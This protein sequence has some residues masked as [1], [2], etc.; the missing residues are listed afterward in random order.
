[1]IL[2]SAMCGCTNMCVTGV[3][4]DAKTREGIGTCLV[5]MGSKARY[6][7]GGFDGVNY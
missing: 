4:S 6:Q 1:M 3:V 5:T 2:L 7:N